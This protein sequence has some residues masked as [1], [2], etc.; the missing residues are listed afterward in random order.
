MKLIAENY[1]DGHYYP[2]HPHHPQ[3]SHP[4]HT[5]Y[6]RPSRGLSIHSNPQPE[7]PEQPEQVR[8]THCQILFI[9][10]Y[11]VDILYIS[12]EFYT[13]IIMSIKKN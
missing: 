1:E 3:H 11:F 5:H 13:K 4:G 2:H 12:A 8:H 7:K 6:R 9:C 10:R